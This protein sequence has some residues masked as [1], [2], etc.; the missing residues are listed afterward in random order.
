MALSVIEVYPASAA[1]IGSQTSLSGPIHCNG[2]NPVLVVGVM[3]YNAASLITVS[4]IVHDGTA[5]LTKIAS[6]SS[7]LTS[8]Y[9]GAELWY[10]DAPS[11]TGNTVTINLSGTATYSCFFALSLAGKT[12]TGID[13][14]ATAQDLVGSTA[15]PICNVD[16][17]HSDCWLVGIGYSRDASRPTAG[18]GTTIASSS[19]TGLCIAHSGGAVGTG[20]QSLHINTTGTGTWPGVITAALSAANASGGGGF[21]ARPYYDMIG[22]GDA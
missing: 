16:V 9:Q 14:Y 18:A 12:V 8:A 22:V 21:V 11:T 17:V 5:S 19:A 13:G 10:T 3:T 20:A 4:S 2:A 6:T 1:W 7:N 15:S